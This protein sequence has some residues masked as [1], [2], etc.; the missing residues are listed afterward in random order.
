MRTGVAAAPATLVTVDPSACFGGGFGGCRAAGIAV[1][2][3]GDR[4]PASGTGCHSGLLL[5]GASTGFEVAP[6]DL[7]L[8]KPL[9]A[10][11]RTT[12]AL[13]LRLSMRRCT[14]KSGMALGSL[15]GQ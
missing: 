14:P 9:A 5:A 12:G 6:C 1:A 2:A 7:L 8:L 3:L 15:L 10:R 11:T 4:G 13:A